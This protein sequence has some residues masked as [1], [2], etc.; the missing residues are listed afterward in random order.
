MTPGQPIDLT[1]AFPDV[2]KTPGQSAP[3]QAHVPAEF[4]RF[5]GA[6]GSANQQQAARPTNGDEAPSGGGGI[7]S[8]V[9]NDA[10]Y[11]VYTQIVRVEGVP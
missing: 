11:R 10:A 3:R 4:Q 7:S 8:S 1:I 6:S 9:V 2:C 5:A